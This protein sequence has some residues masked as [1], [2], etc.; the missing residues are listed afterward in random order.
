MG[1]KLRLR[2]VMTVAALAAAMALFGACGDTG[3]DVQD[4]N[5]TAESEEG[6]NG[7][8]E[9]DSAAEPAQPKGTGCGQRRTGRCRN[10]GK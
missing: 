2:K 6:G 3:G 9:E 1:N 7:E 8:Q 10:R 4:G 5:G